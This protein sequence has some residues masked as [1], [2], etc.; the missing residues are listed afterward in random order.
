MDQ[1]EY[2]CETDR[3]QSVNLTIIANNTKKKMPLTDSSD[4]NNG[5]KESP[6]A[7]PLH[8]IHTFIPI[9]AIFRH[10]FDKRPLKLLQIRGGMTRKIIF[11]QHG[12]I[13]G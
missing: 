10:S 5:V 3:N 7:R 8:L 1:Q 12:Q 6:G 4:D 9:P 2:E 13:S 11:F